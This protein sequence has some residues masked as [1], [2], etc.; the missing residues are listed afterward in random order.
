MNCCDVSLKA[1]G[2]EKKRHN[3]TTIIVNYYNCCFIHIRKRLLVI[4][5]FL[6]MFMNRC[7]E[8]G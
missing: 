2:T 8:Q 6:I 4:W 5:K 1:M 3:N 7:T